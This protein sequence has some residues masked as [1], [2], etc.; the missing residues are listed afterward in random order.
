MLENCF[1]CGEE[2]GRFY[3]NYDVGGIKKKFHMG[4]VKDC[5]NEFNKWRVSQDTAPYVNKYQLHLAGGQSGTEHRNGTKGLRG[6]HRLP[7]RLP[8]AHR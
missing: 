3:V 8:F 6:G 4:M 2:I 1:W 5:L 7:V